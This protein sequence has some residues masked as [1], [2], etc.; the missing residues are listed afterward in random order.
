LGIETGFSWLYVCQ[1][2]KAVTYQP[3][4]TAWEQVARIEGDQDGNIAD[5][6][7]HKRDAIV[8]RR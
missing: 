5:P 3:G 1:A 4:A 2:I 6:K 7:C 8:Y